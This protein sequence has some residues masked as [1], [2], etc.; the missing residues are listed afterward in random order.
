MA[1]AARSPS[2]EETAGCTVFL[3][4][5]PR[6]VRQNQLHSWFE[7]H[8]GGTRRVR[9]VF[10]RRNQQHRGTGFVLFQNA[11]IAQRVVRD[12]GGR[13]INL[14]G[15]CVI[16]VAAYNQTAGDDDDQPPHLI[17][18]VDD[19]H[20]VSD[21][22]FSGSA[23]PTDTDSLATPGSSPGELVVPM[24]LPVRAVAAPMPVV[25]PAAVARAVPPVATAAPVVQVPIAQPPYPV[26]CTPVT[27]RIQAAAV[28]M[29]SAVYFQYPVAA[30]DCGVGCPP[31]RIATHD[32]GPVRTL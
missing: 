16:K 13:G 31:P 2:S 10:D 7:G 20:H 30:A 25:I 26:A 6:G 4:G 14:K 22:E 15:R 21:G 12:Y 5:I 27:G 17:T 23:G 3:S 9:F 8:Y 24:A 28:Q 29:V 11:E 19:E 18:D 1:S 32:A